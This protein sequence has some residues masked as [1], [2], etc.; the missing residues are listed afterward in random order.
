[1]KAFLRMRRRDFI[2]WVASTG[3]L[4]SVSSNVVLAQVDRRRVGVLIGLSED[5]PEAHKYVE[6]LQKALRPF[7]WI[8]RSLLA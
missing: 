6:A 7:G 4:A 5:D 3:A 8:E 1:M 2:A